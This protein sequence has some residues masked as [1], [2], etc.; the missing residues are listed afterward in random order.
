MK[1]IMFISISVIL[2]VITII[3]TPV[4]AGKPDVPPQ[5]PFKELWDAL[6]SLQKQIEA[7]VAA[8]IGADDAL[9]AQIDAETAARIAD[10]DAEQ[11]RA[12]AAEAALQNQ[13]DNIE[14]PKLGTWQSKSTNTVY[15][16]PTDGFVLAYSHGPDGAVLILRGYTDGSNPPTTLRTRAVDSSSWLPMEVSIMMP[17]RK[18]DYWKLESGG[19]NDKVYWIGFGN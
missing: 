8:R 3:A 18:G 6:D 12:Q 1:K 14:M 17:V 10:V 11:A 5:G 15:L 19:W 4:F 13:I 7:E 16:A 9:Q 2:L